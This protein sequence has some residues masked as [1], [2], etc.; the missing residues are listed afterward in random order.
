MLPDFI[1]I[2]QSPL[3]I[4]TAAP[5]HYV[6]FSKH[7]FLYFFKTFIGS[8]SG[9]SGGSRP[10][11]RNRLLP[12]RIPIFLPTFRLNIHASFF[13]VLQKG[14]T[15]GSNVH[16]VLK[17]Y[18]LGNSSSFSLGNSSSF[19]SD[20]STKFPDSFFRVIYSFFNLSP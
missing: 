7:I 2:V 13:T 6:S 12:L 18:S 14:L 3:I 9:G 4:S 15:A 19:S 5:T 8:F 17:Q 16:V 20:V 11:F 1:T 10:Y